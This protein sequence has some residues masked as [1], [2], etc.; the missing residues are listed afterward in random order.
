ME[1][2]GRAIHMPTLILLFS[3][4]VVA[5]QLRLGGFYD[6]IT[7]KLGTLR[8][9]APV[10]LG[11]LILLIGALSAVFSNDVVCLSIAPALIDV[12]MARRL[13]PVPFLLGLACAA[14]IGS[15]ATLIGN[16]QNMLIGARLEVAFADYLIQAA[17]PVL[18]GLIVTWW[19]IVWLWRERWGQDGRPLIP[20]AAAAPLSRW[21]AAKGLTVAATLFGLFLFSGW[22]L[23]IVALGGAGLLLLSRKLHSRQML[24]LVDWQVLLLFIGL[25]IVNEALQ[26]TGLPQQTVADLASAGIDLHRPAILYAF[27]FV[28]SNVVSNVPAVMLLLPIASPSEGLLLALS[29]TLAGNLLVVGSI[30]NIIVMDAAARRNIHITWREHARVG[31]PVTLLTLGFSAAYVL[32]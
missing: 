23:E 28:L 3:F 31:V 26:R 19:I 1:E 7:G 30:A 9:S 6:W 15:A 8:L 32:G 22:P 21:Q 16:P 11:A 5:A 12:C 17:V 25:F 18:A 14:N 20:A 10:L 2:A 4:M 24:G 29:S 13:D 27:T